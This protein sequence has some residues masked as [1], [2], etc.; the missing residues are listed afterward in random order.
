MPGM[1]A[2]FNSDFRRSQTVAIVGVGLIGGSIAAGL[3]KRGHSGAILGVGR[4]E[5]RLDDARKAGLIDEGLSD[6]AKAASRADI[7]I[8]C[9]PVDMIADGVR[10]AADACRAGT[11]LT[12]AG[13]VKGT[14]CRAL[15]GKLSK[16]ATFIGSHP[17]AGSEKQGFRHA[18]ANLFE[19]RI[20]IVTPN[21]TTSADQLLRLKSFWQ[22]LGLAVLEMS[23]DEHDRALAETSHLPH[24][25]AAALAATL[26]PSNRH[27]AATGFCD[28]TRIAAG[29]PDLWTAIFLA[30]AD[31]VLA[32]I[33]SF[34][35]SL[36]VFRIALNNRDAVTLKKLLQVAKTAR[37]SVNHG[38]SH[39]PKN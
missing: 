4:D 17:I 26:S 5:S 28:T 2:P 12:D 16:N 35:D 7:V 24:V 14:I 34:S 6:I 11:L 30:N 31:D 22:T 3:K 13:S 19:G 15:D 37:E 32:R 9:T 29:D 10:S 38:N 33:D 1:A 25:V 36:R 8:F 39:R 20:C 23:P 21:A 18:D 27:L